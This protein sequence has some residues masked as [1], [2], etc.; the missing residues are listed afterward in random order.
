MAKD[1]R[2]AP[3]AK[4]A[5][6]TRAPIALGA[7]WAAALL[8]LLVVLFFHDLVFG[9]KTFVSADATNPVGFVRVGEQSLYRDHIYPL[10]NPYVFLGMPSFASGAT[11]R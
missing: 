10:W 6:A 4:T 1:K 3:K 9:G 8:G 7:A 2:V 11:T 5:R